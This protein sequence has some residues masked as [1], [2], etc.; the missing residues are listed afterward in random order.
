MATTT[1]TT[2][3]DSSLAVASYST[4]PPNCH[5]KQQHT[6]LQ[7]P[8]NGVIGVPKQEDPRNK[9]KIYVVGST[10]VRIRQLTTSKISSLIKRNVLGRWVTFN[11]SIIWSCTN[12]R[13]ERSGVEAPL[14]D[15]YFHTVV[16]T[17]CFNTSRQK[18]NETNRVR[19]IP[20][21]RQPFLQNQGITCPDRENRL[22]SKEL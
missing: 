11:G 21:G 6:L 14:Q 5:I 4:K 12:D 2:L 1:T 3:P 17:V 18:K 10:Q 20:Y 15:S 16:G 7:Q 9:H 8:Y 19:S 13:I 22:Q